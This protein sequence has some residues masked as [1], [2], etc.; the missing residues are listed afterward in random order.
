MRTCQP[1]CCNLVRAGLGGATH[2]GL[3]VAYVEVDQVFRQVGEVAPKEFFVLA[4]QQAFV[5]PVGELPLPELLGCRLGHGCDGSVRQ[6]EGEMAEAVLRPKA[7]QGRFYT[8]T[9]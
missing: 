6:G 3:P 2:P 4:F 1:L 7:W 9:A 5:G 8:L